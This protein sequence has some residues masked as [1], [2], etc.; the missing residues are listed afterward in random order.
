MTTRLERLLRLANYALNETYLIDY[1]SSLEDF[2]ND[3]I[4]VI[5]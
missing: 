4:K 1:H 3:K 2:E 5:N